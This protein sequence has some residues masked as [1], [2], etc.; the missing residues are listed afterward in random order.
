[1]EMDMPQRLRDRDPIY[2]CWRVSA[3]H[4][5]IVR[6]DKGRE[7]ARGK[8]RE[9]AP[10]GSRDQMLDVWFTGIELIRETHERNRMIRENERSIH[11]RPVS[12]EEIIPDHQVAS[13][14]RAR[15]AAA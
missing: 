4:R 1:M 2:V 5:C 6:F 11:V 15:A 13:P 3:I 12:Q 7:W 8:L 10:D 14:D 9:I